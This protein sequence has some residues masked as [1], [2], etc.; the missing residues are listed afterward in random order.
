M[1]VIDK[2]KIASYLSLH[3]FEYITTSEI[4]ACYATRLSHIHSIIAVPLIIENFN[5]YIAITSMFN[6]NFTF[7]YCSCTRRGQH[8]EANTS[9]SN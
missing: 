6:P 9:S 4:R 2:S 5:Q 7:P 1:P 8:D 3:N